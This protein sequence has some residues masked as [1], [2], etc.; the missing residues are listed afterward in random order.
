[1]I[2]YLF[3]NENENFLLIAYPIQV[4]TCLSTP[5]QAKC[6][7]SSVVQPWFLNS[8]CAQLKELIWLL[9]GPCC[10]F[11]LQSRNYQ[12]LDVFFGFTSGTICLRKPFKYHFKPCIFYL[13]TKQNTIFLFCNLKKLALL[14]LVGTP[15]QCSDASLF[16]TGNPKL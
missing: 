12:Y 4:L 7:E 1:M 11:L 6:F 10:F 9:C 8:S 15:T 13:K 3:L 5:F 2:C 16:G 14:I